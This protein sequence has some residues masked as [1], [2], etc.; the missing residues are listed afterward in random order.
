[1]E[2][3]KPVFVG[4]VSDFS[5]NVACKISSTGFKWAGWADFLAKKSVIQSTPAL[6]TPHCYGHPDNKTAAKSP[7]KIYYRRLTEKKYPLLRTLDVKNT[8]SRSQGCP[9]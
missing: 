1:M 3:L 6:R 5:L 2:G 7:A 8:N 4:C 9:Q